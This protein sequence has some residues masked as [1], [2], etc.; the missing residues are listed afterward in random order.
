MKT[1]GIKNSN[2]DSQSSERTDVYNYTQSKFKEFFLNIFIHIANLFLK[3]CSRKTI[4]LYK[5]KA[6][7]LTKE[8]LID[9]P[10]TKPEEVAL[11][12]TE[13][14]STPIETKRESIPSTACARNI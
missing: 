9:R 8:V 6:T 14:T 4:P 10:K 13:K 3:I 11:V 7:H 5:F 1:H 2:I 12:E